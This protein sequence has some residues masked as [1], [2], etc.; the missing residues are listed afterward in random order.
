MSEKFFITLKCNECDHPQCC[1][2]MIAD[3][4]SKKGCVRQVNEDLYIEY[5]H[6]LKEVWPF[7]VKQ[8]NKEKISDTY[9]TVF[10]L[11]DK[12]YNSP[13]VRKYGK[14]LKVIVGE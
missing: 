2:G 14:N 12:V 8:S 13:C 5:Y 6:Q 1:L 9:K 11:L 10:Q 4:E 3:S 7:V